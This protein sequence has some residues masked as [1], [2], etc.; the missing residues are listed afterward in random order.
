LQIDRCFKIC[1]LQSAI[2]SLLLFRRKNAM[3][4]RLPSGP[5]YVEQLEGSVIAK[6]RVQVILETMA[7]TCRVQEACQRLGISEPRFEQL[8]IQILQAALE[9]LEPRPLG[10][11]ARTSTPADERVGALEAQIAELTM[12]LQVSQARTE[13]ALALPNALQTPPE[14]PSRAGG[15]SPTHGAAPNTEGN[16]AAADNGQ[17]AN[18]DRANSPEKKTRRRHPSSQARAPTAKKS[19]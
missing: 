6:Q 1:N 10:R 7:G 13:I 17:A 15:A 8:R 9:R 16:N 2:E 4:G 14:K 3:R 5:E 12:K 11:P 18:P 19:T